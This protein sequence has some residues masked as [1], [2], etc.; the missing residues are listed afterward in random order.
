MTK[1]WSAPTQDR[2]LHDTLAAEREMRSRSEETIRALKKLL[3][4]VANRYDGARLEEI[5]RADPSGIT[6]WS[7]KEWTKFFRE[8]P[9]QMTAASSWGAAGQKDVASADLAAL[10]EENKR[11][12]AYVRKLEAESQ[13]LDISGEEKQAEGAAVPVV[14]PQANLEALPEKPKLKTTSTEQVRGKKRTSGTTKKRDPQVVKKV[15]ERIQSLGTPEAAPK[16]Y[17]G[18][19]ATVLADLLE[20]IK[21][22]PK[23]PPGRWKQILDGKGRRGS[24][25]ELA[26]ERYWSVLWMIGRWGIVSKMELE[27]LIALS[28][29]LSTRS[30][31]LGRVM[32]DLLD[33]NILLEISMRLSKAPSSAL[34]IVQLSEEGRELFSA[35]FELEPVQDELSV[36]NEKHEGERFPDHT[37]AVLIFAL[38][39]RRRGRATKLMPS[40]AGKAAPD[41]VVKRGAE[42][43]YVEVERGQKENDSKWTGIAELNHGKVALC[44]MTEKF[45]RR[46]AA[47]CKL[48]K[49]GKIKSCF[50]TN[51]KELVS[52]RY[53]DIGAETA[54]WLQKW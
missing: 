38:H 28:N 17:V 25:L 9:V 24:D 44:A 11:L 3:V 46:L 19:M 49:S 50:A 41:L 52:V 26:Y 47:D 15:E 32:N 29:K 39:A 51:L 33:A 21:T 43:L 13:T 36:M 31:A 35:L 18:S 37:L 40:V 34:K 16:G 42:T 8:I 12:V 54:L 48:D 2:A 14:N 53:D 7:A 27:T 10:T 1:T 45:Q 6:T 5:R 23:T 4:E 30:G 22:F 20:K